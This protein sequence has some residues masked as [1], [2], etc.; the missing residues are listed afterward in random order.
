VICGTVAP[1][2]DV[3]AKVTYNDHIL[4]IF[5]NACLNCHNPDKKKAGL[6]LSTY[7]GALAG[8]DNG[9]MVESGNPGASFLFKCVKQIEEPKMPPKGEKLTESELAIIEKWIAGQLL[10]TANSKGIVS[11]NNVQKAV[12]SL[13]RPD[14]PPPMPGDLPLEPFVRPRKNTALIALAASPWAPLVAIGGQKQIVLYQTET[15]QPLGVLPFPEGFPAVI[16]FSRNG[17]LLLTGGGLGGKSGQVALWDIQ[18]GERVG[19]VGNEFDQVL[20]ADL[21]PDH[22]SVALGGPGRVLKI[23]STKEGKLEHSIKKHT[24]WITAVAYSP[25][26]RYLASADRAGAV[27]VWEGSTGKEFNT[28]PGHKVAVT[29]LAFMPGVLAS[30]SQDGTIVLWDVKEGKEIRK[31]NAHGGGVEWVDFT[32]DGRVVS[33]GRDKVAK[34]WDQTGKVLFTSAAFDDIALRAALANDR[35]IVGDWTG[36]IRVFAMEGAKKIGDLAANPPPLADQLAASE[37]RLADVRAAVPPLEEKVKS[38]QEKLTASTQTPAAID[39]PAEKLTRLLEQQNADLA[40]LRE[41]RGKQKEGS[42]EYS[43]ANERV[44]AKKAEVAQTQSALDGS[45]TASAKPLEKNPLEKELADAQAALQNAQKDLAVAQ[46]E[47][48]RWQRAQSYMRVHLARQTFAQTKERYEDTIAAAKDAFLP[49]EQLKSQIANAEK[50]LAAG[51]EAV[52]KAETEAAAAAAAVEEARKAI[53]IAEG[54]FA[55]KEAAAKAAADA[56]V[57]AATE[58]KELPKKLQQMETQVATAQKPLDKLNEDIAK[59]REERSKIAQD[60]PEYAAAD[61][62]V[63][64][65]KPRIAE[66]TMKLEAAKAEFAMV[67][68]RVDGSAAAQAELKTKSDGATAEV[69]KAKEAVD[70]AKT[71]L[72]GLA[73]KANVAERALIALQAKLKT[74][75]TALADARKK[76]PET[77]KQAQVTKAT[78]EKDAVVLAK[79]LE[80]RKVEAERAKSEFDTKYH[81]VTRSAEAQQTAA[82]PKG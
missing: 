69:A 58:A 49:V 3:P 6:D 70:A 66:A 82:N 57:A 20:G 71:T 46:S 7:Q 64:E 26:G 34:V 65:L 42:P 79:E 4:P 63:Q 39:N 53:S 11:S 60:A 62:K 72:K 45:K 16:R 35:V 1:A 12:V 17:Q 9:K 50:E 52:K 23:Y 30:G 48:E 59:R 28:L 51:P 18:T 77:E 8:S 67:K 40:K 31:W 78:A 29:S 74:T 38:L 80:T 21:S 27:V 73:D 37:K 81:P 76:L 22:S 10:E 43:A 68:A 32:P 15:L 33:C 24:D 25:D 61:A 55:A 41:E 19:T 14:G 2:A 54:T 75:E 36:S 13:E 5:R 56:A 47:F 44:Q